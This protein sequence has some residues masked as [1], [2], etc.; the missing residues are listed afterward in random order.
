LWALAVYAVET[1]D[2]STGVLPKSLYS[3][4]KVGIYFV[5]G[6]RDGETL[7]GHA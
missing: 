7:R 1:A 2:N 5:L 6:K 4:L 3:F